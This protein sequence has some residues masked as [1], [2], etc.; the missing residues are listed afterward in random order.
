MGGTRRGTRLTQ[1]EAAE[2]LGV[3]VEAIR[4]R[5]KRGTLLSEKGTDGRRY[6]YLDEALD[7]APPR[8]EEAGASPLV[9][10]LRD[11]IEF[12]QRELER[13][14]AILLNMTEAM[15]AISPPAPEEPPTEAPGA[16]ET[17]TEQPGRVG[18]Q[19]AVPGAQEGSQRAPW[20]RRVF[21]A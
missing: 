14:D 6:V 4:K 16:P 18:P 20:W 7:A 12:L 17:A 10:E 5:V 1:R 3:S 21:G 2:R 13:K 9:E 15:K 8:S 19:A 11:R